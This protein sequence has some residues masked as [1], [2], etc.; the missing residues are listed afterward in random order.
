MKRI[1]PITV[2][3]VLTCSIATPASAASS[4]KNCTAMRKA[5]PGGVAKTKAAAKKSGAKYAPA[6]Y[7]AN[8]KMDRDKDG[9]AC[10]S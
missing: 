10:E 5:Y 3:L 7:A 9:A 4:F 2:A 1:V 8:A 6:I